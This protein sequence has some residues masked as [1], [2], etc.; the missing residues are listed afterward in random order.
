MITR[1]QLLC[2]SLLS[3]LLIAGFSADGAPVGSKKA[4]EEQSHLALKVKNLPDSLF[5]PV[6]MEDLL[7][8][9][10]YL[11]LAHEGWSREEIMKIMSTAIADKKA[12]KNKIGYGYY[13][14]Q[15]LPTYGLQ[16]GGDS[17]YMFIDTLYTEKMRKSVAETVP[18]DLLNKYWEPIEYIPPRL[19]TGSGDANRRIGGYFRCP[20]FKPFCGRMHWLIA[21]PDNPDRIYA[22][23]DGA[24]IYKTDNC[25]EHW[26][27]ITDRIPDRANRSQCNGYAIPVDPDDWDHVFAFMNNYTVY[28]TTDGG[29]SWRRIQ[30]ATH[31]GRFKRGDCFRDRDGN[32]KFIG[33][34]QEG[35][36]N[37]KV[38]IS[39]DTC[40]TW[41]EVIVPNELKDINPTNGTRG[42]WFQYIVFDPTDRN[43]IYLPT[44]RSILYF[45]DGAKSTVV[46]GKKTYNI[47]KL[48]FEVY[49]QEHNARRYATGI[50]EDKGA[51]A[52]NNT[53][54]PCPGTHVGQLIIN[55]N[56]PEQWWFATGSYLRSSIPNSAVYRSDDGGKTWITLQDLIYGIGSGNAYGNELPKSWLG[57]FG[58]NFADTSKV[59]GCSMSSAHSV[60]GGRNFTQYAWGRAIKA[61]HDDGIYHYV[62]ASRHNADNH[63][64]FSH[65]SGRIFRGSDGGMLM[66]D[67]NINNGEWVSIGGDMGQMLFYH[68][69]VNEFGDQVMAGNTQDIDGQT[70]RY[71]RWTK[72]R[73]YE[74]CESFINP[75]T[76]AVYFPNTG[77]QGLDPSM[78]T[79][80]SWE[81]ATTRADVVSGSWFIARSGSGSNGRNFL[82]C[83]DQGQ[84]LV[85]LQPALGAPLGGIFGK[86]GLCRDKGRTTIFAITNGHVFKRSI[87]GGKTFETL[88]A[89]SGVDAK[90]SNSVIATDPNNSDIFYMGQRGK[91]YLYDV[92]AGTWEM[93]GS[94]LPD[95]PCTNLLFHEG[96]GDL[97][98]FHDGSAGIYILEYNK[99]TG[100]YA[101]NWRFWVKGYNA[102]KAK[103]VEINY[104]TQEMVICDYGHSVWVADLEHPCDRYFDNGFRLKELSFK[105]GRRTIGIDTEWTIPMYHYYKWTVNGEEI[106][107]PY[108][109]L[110][111]ELNP[112][113]RVQLELTLRES[114][115][116]H[117]LSA[118][119][120]VPAVGDPNAT[121]SENP[122]A[123]LAETDGTAAAPA[124]GSVSYETPL[125]K[126]AGY[127]LYSNG[128]GRVD[129][130][131]VDYFFEDFTID[132]W[133]KPNGP[134]TILA[135]TTRHSDAKGF[136]LSMDGNA[137]KFQYYPL[138]Q[139]RLS[140]NEEGT[141]VQNAAV[142][143][144]TLMLG[145]WN[146]VA[147][148]H[149]RKGNIVLYVNG[150]TVASAPRINPEGSLN[151]TSVLSLFADAIEMYP[152]DAAVDELK[153]WKRALTTDEVRREMHSTD[154]AD[155]GSLVAY[156]P[157]NTGSLEN[158]REV[159]TGK[160]VKSRVLAETTYPVMPVPVCAKLA[161]CDEASGN[162]HV[163]QSKGQDFFKIS[164]QSADETAA[165]PASASLSGNIGVYA[166]DADNW[167]SADDNMNNDFFDVYPLGYLIHMF[168]G[169]NAEGNLS[170]EIYPAE[171]AFSAEKDYRLYATNI[172]SDKQTWEIY[173]SVAL[174]SET[175]N[176]TVSDLTLND[177]KDKKLMLVTTKPSIELQVEGL[178]ADGILEVYDESQVARTITATILSGLE[179]PQDVYNIIPDGIVKA[180]GLYFTHG[181][182]TGELRLDMSK[183][184]PFNSTVQATLRSN[185]NRVL[186]DSMNPD[187]TGNSRPS[188]IPL[189]IGVRNRIMPR[190]VGTAMKI[191][192]GRAD[193]GNA[194]DA[195]KLSGSRN[196]TIMGWIRID[197]IK[198]INAV[199]FNLFVLQ[200]QGSRASDVTG[201]RVNQGKLE[202]YLNDY[203]TSAKSN[204]L[205]L[206]AADVGVWKHIAYV[207]DSAS[208]KVILYLNGVPHAFNRSGAIR[209][210]VGFHIGKN[211]GY[212][213]VANTDNFCG[214][215]DQVGVWNRALT[216]DEIIKYM[217]TAPSLDDPNMVYYL[218]MDYN[219]ED[220]T[221]RDCYST[222]EIKNL[223]GTGLTGSASF[224]EPISVPFDARA[225]VSASDADSPISLT[226]PATMQ[227]NTVI[228]TFRGTPYC[229]INHEFQDYTAMAQEFYGITYR[230]YKNVQP[231]ETDTVTLTYRHNSIMEGERLAVALREIGTTDH[232][233]GFIHASSVTAG[234]AVFK[235]PA[236]YLTDAS[237][238]MFFNYPEEGEDG[239]TTSRLASVHLGFPASLSNSINNDG[240]IPTI[241]LQEDMNTIPVTA[242]IFRLASNN[243]SVKIIVN[244]STYASVSQK[245][246]DFSK[247]VN[248][249]D[250]NIDMDKIDPYGVNTLTI[251]LEGAESNQLRLNFYL[252]PFVHLSL[253]NGEQ[254]EVITPGSGSKSTT[255]S[256]DP[257]ET[258]A[259]RR[260]RL[261]AAKE[262]GNTVTATTAVTSLKVN[263]EMLQG[264]LPEGEN[265]KLEVLT[266]L[267]YSMN[268][269]NGT[270]FIDKNVNIDNLEHHPSDSGQLHE[271][272]NLIG[273]PYLKNINLTKSQNV[274]FDPE[275]ITKYLYQCDP[276]TGNYKV[277]DMTDYNSAQKIQPF[278]AYFV[279]AMAPE[280]SLTITPIAGEETPTKRTIAYD[281]VEKQQLVLELSDGDKVVDEVI[282]RFDPGADNNFVVNE[283]AAKLWNLTS[284]SPELYAVTHDG[285]NAAVHVSNSNEGTLGVKSPVAKNLTLT[286]KS[287]T[288]LDENKI[289]I[290]DNVTEDTWMPATQ[291]TSHVFTAAEGDNNNRFH[292]S[293]KEQPTGLDGQSISGYKVLVEDLSC[294]VTGL[295]GDAVVNIYNVAGANVVGMETG[296]PSVAVTLERGV[297]IVVI[298]E[299]GKEYIS[300]IRI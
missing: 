54:F 31:K 207:L 298:R 66:L 16:P 102:S 56:N 213:A 5:A 24:G 70:Y 229:Y 277:F 91:V 217:Y 264:Y 187:T 125:T 286:L 114:P 10:V 145:Q 256:T 196:A 138:H 96:S 76:S 204:N 296:E 181:K 221:M 244:E 59:Y 134:G 39:E 27:C 182:A 165:T 233:G 90:F 77:Y 155:D 273:N 189:P 84:K 43:K 115:D 240:E 214:A 216:Q 260:S 158:E 162:E 285:V 151:N 276:V 129:L 166:F 250:V 94:G 45:D 243:D 64:I 4:K 28:E 288:G 252:E 99:E 300:K 184:G 293:F 117:T 78:I 245:T 270:L 113:D 183:L 268:I 116:V 269:G 65:K 185:D 236:S 227:R 60:D 51:D 3:L 104:T 98:F 131:Y 205:T 278:Q 58:V 80:N 107:N 110:R 82:R 169:A 201:I 141:I 111:R 49:D 6:Q 228:A 7:N 92:N 124:A 55:P 79:I 26:E 173:G 22:V 283:D 295:Q 242:D 85:N 224:E 35:G 238:V 106:D 231:A 130:G 15:W 135:N 198:N 258:P 255:D 197:S 136:E 261:R 83:D 34:T 142:K 52:S 223:T 159:F 74:G 220:G 121:P 12:A 88:K 40:K 89:A 44:A 17:L 123:T 42:L 253:L 178:G 50:A 122:I 203:P 195:S 186:I 19:R 199:G 246:I 188:L 68:I 163:F 209:P 1:K 235:V 41:T 71:G 20:Q 180:S 143:G 147:V 190:E 237:E 132:F 271:G 150:E 152:I 212:G 126:E 211:S 230:D 63:F 100:E 272:W 46:N 234:E 222:A 194:A 109:Y 137:L 259:M 176:L 281:A 120:I 97:Y 287:V 53:I 81:N 118:E 275:L 38:W 47:K 171:G 170:M 127:A 192:N 239:S 263:A 153:I 262:T 164:M 108:Q 48:S 57:G 168:N 37:S 156:Y 218:N 219:D 14:K 191:V 93:L 167:Q 289:A 175:G 73:G 154:I 21:K 8:D 294:I 297:Y 299:N 292:V 133:L 280:A 290:H 13:A 291:G 225:I 86:F 161:A 282:I 23:P 202:Y 112:G 2:S 284:S 157:F 101:D 177:I 193:I 69:A 29:Q 247:T 215:A 249:F 146:H 160:P 266:D 95:I 206:G 174:N 36:W 172:N 11:K 208:G 30:G 33:C 241:M 226:F 251:T 32:L 200:H 72:W 210:V 248:H 87:D 179:E 149:Q 61:K 148:T 25:G 128:K 232:L 67:P 9:E 274:K 279:Q 257:A 144:G 140:Y 139:V 119:Y 62:A 265:V 254:T 75:Y 103:N 267:D 105:D 18:E